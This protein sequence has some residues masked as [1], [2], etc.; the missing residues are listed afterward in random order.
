M[1]KLSKKQL[2][3]RTEKQC[4]FCEEGDYNLLDCHRIIPGAEGGKYTDYNSLVICSNCHRKC[5]SGAIKV[6]GRHFSTTGR[7]VLNYI[8]DGKECWK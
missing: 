1:K 5:H 6:I 4:Y 7:Y 2:M 8:E 3:K